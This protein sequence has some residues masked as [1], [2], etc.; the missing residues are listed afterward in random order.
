MARATSPDSFF[1]FLLETL[2]G[3]SKTEKVGSKEKANL[4]R[5]E[6][7]VLIV[8]GGPTGLLT[9]SLLNRSGSES[10]VTYPRGR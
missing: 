7:P 5:D 1:R 8:G 3:T 2:F 10:L 6:V 4:V 9:A